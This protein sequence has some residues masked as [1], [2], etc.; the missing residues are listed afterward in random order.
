M[1]K[2]FG[3]LRVSTR[4]QGRSGLGLD[5]QREAIERFAKAEGY[6]IAE[7]VEE[8]QSGKGWDALDRRPKLAALLKEA[9]RQKAPVIVAKVDRLSR[10]VAFGSAILESPVRFIAVEAGANA[11][12][13][14][15]HIRMVLAEEERKRIADRTRDALAQAKRRGRKLG[16]LKTLKASRKQG[17]LTQ[18]RQADQFATSTAPLIEAYQRQGL[19]LRQIAEEMNKRGIPTARGGQ[20]F[21]SMICLM[22]R[23]AKVAA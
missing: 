5:A 23:R 18:K 15:L 19:T 21:A 20:W 4:E 17:H 13:F 16:N 10:N 8:V 14:N 22:L 7:W 11:D 12:K 2:A 6:D 3:Y 1:I 9:K